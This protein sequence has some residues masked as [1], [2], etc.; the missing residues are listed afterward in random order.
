MT[1]IF[2]VMEQSVLFDKLADYTLKYTQLLT[3]GGFQQDVD[4]CKLMIEELQVEIE[5]RKSK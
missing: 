2:E 4:N 3:E 1:N 5:K